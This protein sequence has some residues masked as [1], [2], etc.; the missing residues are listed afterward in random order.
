MTVTLGELV[1]MGFFLFWI[2]LT[3]F[4]VAYLG[5]WTDLITTKPDQTAALL[6]GLFV[7]G[8][9]FAGIELSKKIGGF[10]DV[11]KEKKKQK[12]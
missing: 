5:D 7:G 4:L 9:I 3:L 2:A 11:W 8:A 12:G 6:R 10:I 1:G